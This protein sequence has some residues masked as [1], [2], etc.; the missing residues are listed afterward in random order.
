MHRDSRAIRH[1]ASGGIVGLFFVGLVLMVLFSSGTAGVIATRTSTPTATTTVSVE[2]A[3]R[4]QVI[5]RFQQIMTLR[6]QALRKLDLRVLRSIYTPDSPQL[7]RDRTEIRTMRRKHERWVGLELPVSI[8]KA[9]AESS[10]RWTIVA[11]LGR[12][13]A[14]LETSSGELIRKVH[15]NRQVYWCSLVKDP[16]KGWLL[17]R[18]VPP[19][20]LQPSAR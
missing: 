12:A 18:L 13:D 17:Y 1:H 14:R 16:G 20:S 10:R 2:S 5:A 3:E 19:E 15:G 7:R 11:L 4:A 8:L 6:Q 9:S